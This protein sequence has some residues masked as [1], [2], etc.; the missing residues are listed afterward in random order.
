M[1]SFEDAITDSTQFS[2]RHLLL[3]NGFS[4]ALRPDIF[5]YGSLFQRADFSNHSQLPKVFDALATQDFELAIRS[6]EAS[7]KI[8]PIYGIDGSASS[9]AMLDDAKALKDI[10]VETIAANHPDIPVDIPDAKFW[11]C[12]T[13]LHYFLG[14]NDGQVFTLNYDLLLY[15]TLMHE[16]APLA[17]EPIHLTTNDGFGNDETDPTA[18]YVV[19]QGET[20]AHSARVH[21]LHGALHLFDAGDDLQKYTWIRT[22]AR[23]VDQARSAIAGNKF[24]L[25]VAE[26]TSWQKKAKIRHNAYLYQGFKQLVANAQQ[27]KVCF[28]IH[29][30]S[31]AENDD[32]IL[33]RLG[34]GRFPKL[35]VSLFGDPSSDSNKHIIARAQALAEMRKPSYPL[36]VDFYDAASAKVWG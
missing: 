6:L 24:P 31:L 21:F 20:G 26:G 35:Y 25:F 16:D 30:H 36:N 7:A 4:I 32:H 34:T 9:V 1:W 17:T 3:G 19:W 18:D 2:K 14:P 22:N 11:A 8:I 29:G 12:R 10:L 13:F 5:H 15:W 33:R 23:L 27:T 28:F